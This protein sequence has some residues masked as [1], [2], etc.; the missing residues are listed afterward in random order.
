MFAKKIVATGLAVLVTLGLAACDPPMPPE[1]AAA[2]AERT[3]TCVDGN[4][5]VATPAALSDL[6]DGWVT[7]ISAACKGMTLTKAA[8]NDATANAVISLDGQAPA[9]YKSFL[10]VP[11]AYNAGVVAYALSAAQTL[12][13]TPQNVADIFS[14]RITNWSDASIAKANPNTTLPSEAIHVVGTPQ[15]NEIDA[16]TKWFKTKGVS[17]NP[18]L[19]KVSPV[20]SGAYLTKM[21]EGDIAITSFSNALISYA[22]VAAVTVGADPAKDSAVPDVSG[23]QRGADKTP[24]ATADKTQTPPYGAVYPVTISLGGADNQLARAI[25]RY[26]VRQDAQGAVGSSVIAPLPDSV[27]VS[28]IGQITKGLSATK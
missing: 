19:V 6:V 25:A 17:F 18:T 11:F 27:R 13:L 12:N 9:G 2:Q 21:A 16:L 14:G 24:A 23:V 22:A 20:D 7:S 3:V 10:T 28:V 1:I 8:A 5:T 15:Q 26:L 4:L